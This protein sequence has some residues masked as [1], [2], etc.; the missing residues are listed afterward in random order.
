MSLNLF[1]EGEREAFSRCPPAGSDLLP[2]NYPSHAS[3]PRKKVIQPTYPS[4]FE[5]SE[6]PER[7]PILFIRM[8][9]DPGNISCL[10][11]QYELLY[12]QG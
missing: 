12:P 1:W 9:Q 4:C 10:P 11:T 5:L 2:K 3:D 8:C 6:S 7:L